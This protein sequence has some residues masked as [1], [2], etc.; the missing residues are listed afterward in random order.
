ML[1]LLYHIKRTHVNLY[2]LV[3]SHT[4]HPCLQRDYIS[5]IDV[6]AVSAT[7][8]IDTSISCVSKGGATIS[9]LGHLINKLT[10]VIQIQHLTLLSDKLNKNFFF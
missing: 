3:F 9:R 7:W 6:K 1:I 10:Q 5:L 8:G 4:C 2:P